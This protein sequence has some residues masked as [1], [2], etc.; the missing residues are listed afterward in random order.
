MPRVLLHPEILATALQGE[1]PSGQEF[2]LDAETGKKLTRVLRLCAGEP[3]IGFDGRGREWDCILTATGRPREDDFERLEKRGTSKGKVR[4]LIVAPRETSA[5]SRLHLSVAQAVPKNDK[6]EW[7]LQKGTELGVA[8][9]WPFEAERTV[10]RLLGGDEESA[11]ATARAERWRRIAAG[12]AAQCGRADVPIIHAIADL[13]TVIGAGANAGRCFLLDES[14]N[15]EP[16]R[17]A[18]EREPLAL[19]N[20]EP[21]KVMLLVGPEGGWSESEREQ[22]ERYGAESV[23]LGRL[24]LRTETAALVAAALLQWEAGELG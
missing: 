4:A 10:A 9:F 20:D 6:M 7:V 5:P 16:L 2:D 11:R 19:E 12:A 21:M 24:I 23:H 1:E 18:L 3:F 17:A 14:E 8:E 15:A 22:A 13:S